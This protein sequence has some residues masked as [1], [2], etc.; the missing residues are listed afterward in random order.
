MLLVFDCLDLLCLWLVVMGSCFLFDFICCFDGG[1]IW[2]WLLL[3]LVVLWVLLAFDNCL[4]S[5][6]WSVCVGMVVCTLLTLDLLVVFGFGGFTWFCKLLLTRW[7][8][9]GV[10]TWCFGFGVWYWLEALI[11]GGFI[12]FV[13]CCWRF[14]VYG[15]HLYWCSFGLYFCWLFNVDYVFMPF[16]LFYFADLCRCIIACG[17]WFWLLDFDLLFAIL[18]SICYLF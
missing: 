16:N 12:F 10:C 17:G 1:V 7:I 3:V 2:I 15:C 5:V 14:V 6:L 8:V 9:F 4:F 11:L 13:V 18:V